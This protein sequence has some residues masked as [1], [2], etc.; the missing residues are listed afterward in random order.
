MLQLAYE[1]TNRCDIA[2]L[3]CLRDKI[4]PRLDVD[5]ELVIRTLD[6]A[7]KM[8]T[9]IIS[10]TG[11]EP[12]LHPDYITILDEVAKRGFRWIT[13]TNAHNTELFQEVFKDPARRCSLS[14]LAISVDGGNEKTHDKI[15]GKGSFKK[16]VR[17]TTF[18]KS[19]KIPFRFQICLTRFNVGEI[20]EFIILASTLGAHTAGFGI[21]QPTKKN[22]ASGLLLSP[23]EFR[24]AQMKIDQ[25]KDMFSI[26]IQLNF[27]FFHPSPMM[28]CSVLTSNAMNIDYLG[29]MIFCCQ[30]SNFG[31]IDYVKKREEIIADL[32]EVSLLDGY[33]LMLE[34]TREY[35]KIKAQ[36]AARGEIKGLDL[37][38]CNYCAK[39]FGKMDWAKDDPR[40]RDWLDPEREL[41]SVLRED[42]PAERSAAYSFF[43]NY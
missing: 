43:P 29:N 28:K 11:G 24:R 16:I 19:Q 7:Q 27:G 6:E 18:L 39:Q 40:V 1:L 36:R 17:T 9:R 12:T 37:Y 25:I 38:P 20:E 10:F 21:M 34:R 13:V 8:G 15:R 3:H 23:E 2:C 31:D 4:E 42:A 14:F 5:T 41:S 22:V 33:S 30:L 35:N 32:H 26:N